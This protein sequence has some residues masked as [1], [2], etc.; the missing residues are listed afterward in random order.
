VLEVQCSQVIRIAGARWGIETC[1]AEA[2]VQCGRG[3]YQV[4][5]CTSWP[6]HVTLAMFAH[7]F[8]QN[9]AVADANS[10]FDA[11]LRKVGNG[12]QPWRAKAER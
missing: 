4:R 2:K 9:T 3:H 8:L 6:R 1:F 11:D 10:G 12:N 5:T 7:V